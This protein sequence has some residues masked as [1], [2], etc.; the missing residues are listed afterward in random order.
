MTNSRKWVET[1]LA[2]QLLVFATLWVVTFIIYLPAIKAG[3][4]IDT[5]GWLYN[6]RHLSFLDYINNAQ[7]RIPSLYQFT[8]FTT[9]LFYKVFGASPLA[10]HT[11]MVTMQACN[12]YLLFRLTKAILADSRIEQ[13][14]LIA[15]T[16]VLAYTI[17]PHIS[18]VIIWE[19]SFH[20]LQGFLF[21]LG[22][23]LLSRLYLLYG[24]ARY[25]IWGAILYF[26]STWSLEVFYLT[27]WLVLTLAAYY[28]LALQTPA[29]KF[30][31]TI[32]A[33][34]VPQL[35][36]FLLNIFVLRAVF[37][38]H[39]A[40][41]AEGVV[42]P[43]V[44]YLCKTPQYIFHILFFG[45]FFDITIRE[46]V[47]H[48][49]Q[50]TPFLITFYAICT[51]LF[52]WVCLRLKYAGNTGKVAMY[53]F[54]SMCIC[55]AIII[56]LAFPY[57]LLVF[58]DRYT[59]FLTAFLFMLLALG[60]ISSAKKSL[61]ILLVTYMAIN[62]FFTIKLNILWKQ[63]TYVDNRLLTELPAT[64]NKTVL[65]L[66]MP[67]NLKGVPMIGA[68]PDGMYQGM[69]Q[70][71]WGKKEPVK[72][73]DVMSFNMVTMH[74]GTHVT[75]VNDSILKVTLNQWSTWWW[76]EGHGG[77]S[78]ETPDYR[79]DLVDPGHWFEIKLKHPANNYLL[80]F[81][82]NSAWKAVDMANKGDQY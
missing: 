67:E 64:G 75:V 51:A 78:Y 25:A 20:Y 73:Y 54:V 28:R 47:Y 36:M 2:N 52:A 1:L 11:L 26:L 59:Y 49:C 62:L 45:R 74:D 65:L 10:W 38:N 7:S 17:S 42:Q 22:I 44:S 29:V 6:I 31:R 81:Q 32:K 41:I 16:G 57:L 23:L 60:A 21:I 61:V 82:N 70:L 27:P 56:P 77:R 9:Y 55:L 19:A 33:F 12:A 15:F 76:Y 13:T 66:S 72:I 4:V 79:V 58:Y 80:L 63:A 71:L 39:F 34:V 48:I 53:L 18:E 5:A 30:R 40:H 14:T 3:W 50:S 43:L 69:R 46:Q 8:Q 37:G 24:G 35:A 68:Q